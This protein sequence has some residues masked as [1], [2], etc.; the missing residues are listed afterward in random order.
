[1]PVASDVPRLL[2]VR[3]NV[4]FSPAMGSRGE[5]LLAQ[6]QIGYADVDIHAGA[7]VGGVEIDL[8]GADDRA[9]LVIVCALVPGSTVAVMVRV[10]GVVSGTASIVHR[11]LVSS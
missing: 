5:A 10:A 8:I 11:W 7:V 4:V 2:S 6:R 1:M 9:V 3:V